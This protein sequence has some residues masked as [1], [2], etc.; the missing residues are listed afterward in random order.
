MNPKVPVAI[1]MESKKMFVSAVLWANRDGRRSRM[2]IDIRTI[3]N[4]SGRKYVIICKLIGK[5]GGSER[6]GGVGNGVM[7]DGSVDVRMR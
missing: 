4:G 5:S 3:I 7:H 1:Y 2:R 6:G